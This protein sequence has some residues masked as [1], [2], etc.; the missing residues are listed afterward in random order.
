M[1]LL[2]Q[3]N[4]ITFGYGTAS[5][6][7]FTN[8]QDNI[9][10]GFVFGKSRVA[11]LKQITIPRL[12]LAAAT[13]AVKVD[14]MLTKELHLPL[15]DSTFWTDSTSVL[16]YIHNQTKRFH[17]FVVNR[18]AVIHDLSRTTQWK[19]V[20]SRDN[21]ADDA[22]HGLQVDSFLRS[23]WLKGPEF[24]EKREW[25]NTSQNPGEIPPDDPEV[26]KRVSQLTV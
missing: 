11:P 19:H 17:T 22:S 24:P 21:P 12:E 18:I 16:K 25:P 3:L 14:Q 1:T 4:F 23:R 9:H 13:L 2:G 10:V 8:H 15:Q 26:K 7:R 20:N 5:Y 6:V